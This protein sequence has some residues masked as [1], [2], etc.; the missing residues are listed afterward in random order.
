MTCYFRR[1]AEA[2]RIVREPCVIR[3]AKNF[4]GRLIFKSQAYL[5]RSTSEEDRAFNTVVKQAYALL[6]TITITPGRINARD[7]LVATLAAALPV[8]VAGSSIADPIT[9]QFL[10]AAGQLVECIENIQEEFHRNQRLI[11]TQN[12]RNLSY[13]I[14]NYQYAFLRWS[15]RHLAPDHETQRR[16]YSYYYMAQT[17]PELRAEVERYGDVGTRLALMERIIVEDQGQQV[18]NDLVASLAATRL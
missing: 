15:K 18:F 13:M 4:M 14:P 11:Y 3:L 2:L 6:G 17:H 8:S 5:K 10:D 16:Y 1:F 7:T 12:L 9:Q